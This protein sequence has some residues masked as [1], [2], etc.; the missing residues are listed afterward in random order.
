MKVLV[1]LAFVAT[2]SVYARERIVGGEIAKN[3]EFPSIVSLQKSSFGGLLWSHICGGILISSNYVLTAAHCVDG[4]SASTLRVLLG[5]NDLNN[6]N[7]A[8]AQRINIAQVTM[9]E[10]YNSN[11]DG[12]PNDVAVLRLSSTANLVPGFVEVSELSPDNTYAGETAVL[13]GWGKLAGS[14]STTS[15]KLY[16]L[17]IPVISNDACTQAW[18]ANYIMETH[19]CVHD[20]GR[21]SGACNGDSGGPMYCSNGSGGYYVCGVTSWG[22]NGCPGTTPSVY[23]RVSKFASWIRANTDL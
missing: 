20:D 19:I 16:R 23:G 17:D 14:E 1:I 4:S 18:G 2:A 11:A 7:E 9:H 3:N 15:S 21:E 6:N 13:A 5:R 8:N 22:Q 10:G 12:F